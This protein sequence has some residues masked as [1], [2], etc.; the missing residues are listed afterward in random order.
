MDVSYKEAYAMNPE[1]ARMK[2]V[3]TYF[4]CGCIAETARRWHNLAESGPQVGPL[5]G[6]EVFTG[7][8][9]VPDVIPLL[10]EPHPKSRPT[11]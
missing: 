2:L 5:L 3:E 8:R 6:R 11:S 1:Q 4:N 9:T 7:F 10:P